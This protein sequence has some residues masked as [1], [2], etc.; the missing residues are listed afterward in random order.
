MTA[1]AKFFGTKMIKTGGSLVRNSRQQP[2]QQGCAPLATSSSI[3][4]AIARA[5]TIRVW[6]RRGQRLP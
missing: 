6:W 1:F 3:A 4:I 2:L 5:S